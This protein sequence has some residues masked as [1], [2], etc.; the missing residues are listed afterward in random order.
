MNKPIMLWNPSNEFCQQAT[1]LKYMEW[2]NDKYSL[3]LK[4]Y[5]DIHTWSVNN[6]DNFWRSLWDYFHVIR[7]KEPENILEYK[8]MIDARWFTGATLNYAN[9]VLNLA[10]QDL[11]IISTNEHGNIRRISRQELLGKVGSLQRV[12]ADLGVKEGDRVASFLPNIPEAMISLYATN[13]LGAIWSSSSPDFGSKGI[14]D[15]FQQI[16]PKVLIAIDGYSYNGKRYDRMGV[17]DEILSKISSIK[18]VILLNYEGFSRENGKFL[19]F[20]D[21]VKNLRTPQFKTLPFNH[22]L[23]I[24]YSS[25]TTGIPKAIVQSQGGILLEHLK[26]LKLHY[27]LDKNKRFF[28][29][30]TTGWMMWNLVASSISTGSTAVLYDGSATYPDNYFLWE[31]AEREK[32]SFFGVSAAYLTFS[33]KEMLDVR[34]KYPLEKMYAIG[35]TGSPLPP[36]AFRYV[37][38]H[39]RSDVLLASISGGTDVCTSFLG[40]CPCEP[41]YEG[42]LQCINLGADI[43]SFDDYGNELIDEMGELVIKKPMPSMPIYLWG[44]EAKLKLRETYF[45]TYE[46]L[47]RHGD[48]IIITSR[49]TA[50]ILGRSD[51][52]L[53]RKGIRIGTAEIYRVVDEMKAVKDSLVIGIE[54]PGGEYYMPLFVSVEKGT[55][56]S[57]LK[58]EIKENIRKNL[59]PRHVPDDIIQVSDIPRTIN[60]KKMEV[61]IKKII[62]GFPV[63]KALNISSMANPECLEEF[64]RIAKE[65]REKYGITAK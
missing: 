44:D 61:P 35:S 10:P 65:I 30:T 48:W 55:D 1:M 3:D 6:L 17:L 21:S 24:L 9:N 22:P 46:G 41:V 25:G 39:V 38:E 12:L 49:G 45:S 23:W 42:E 18:N 8:E 32:I 20:Q 31:L 62:M 26:L 7:E 56:F 64:I 33:M 14:I 54:I 13:S 43:H 63:E 58:E 51:S 52:T 47:W 28:W 19:D 50:I 2:V 57:K 5:N 36:E 60:G 40:G 11:P 15:R 59:T 37:Y 16:S 4:N 29:Y 27:N 53:K 34:N